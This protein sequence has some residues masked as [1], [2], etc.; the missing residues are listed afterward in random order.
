VALGEG[1]AGK[2]KT[3]RKLNLP[4]RVRGNGMHTIYGQSISE[5]RGRA[6]LSQRQVAARMRKED[7]RPISPQCLVFS[8]ALRKER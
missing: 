4:T 6:N 1:S 2:E 3:L 8:K 5:A 7:G